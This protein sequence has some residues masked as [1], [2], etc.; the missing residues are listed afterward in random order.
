MLNLGFEPLIPSPAFSAVALAAIALLAWYALRR[1]G[2]VGRTT[3]SAI[4]AL[5][6]ASVALVLVVLL[7]PTRAKEIPTPGGKP[8]L[9]L[10][11]DDSSSMCTPDATG[12]PSR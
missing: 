1:P 9:T 7:N 11:I 12:G 2:E 4:V 10:L 5:M 3:W 6:S 8:L